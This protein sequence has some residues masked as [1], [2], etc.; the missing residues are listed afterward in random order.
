MALEVYAK[1]SYSLRPAT[2]RSNN[3]G[4]EWAKIVSGVVG[5]VMPRAGNAI[6]TASRL[7][8]KAKQAF[9]AGRAA[10]QNGKEQRKG[11]QLTKNFGAAHSKPAGARRQRVRR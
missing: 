8:P 10:I 9:N 3:P 2:L 1:A 6:N 5:S 11:K 7:A 4:G